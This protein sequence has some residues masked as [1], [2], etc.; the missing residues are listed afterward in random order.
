MS[1]GSPAIDARLRRQV[2]R[3][4]LVGGLGFLVD[5]GLL[6]ALVALGAN[7]YGARV[8]SF[9]AAVTVTWALNRSWTFEQR[10]RAGAGRSYVGYAVVQVTGALANFL[11]YTGVLHFLAPTPGNAVL[12]LACGAV[13]G[14]AVNFTGARLVFTPRTT[15]GWPRVGA[16]GERRPLPR[17][18]ER[19]QPDDAM[20]YRPEIDGLRAVAVLPVVLFHA[21]FEAFGGG[22]VGVDVFFVISG[23]LITGIIIDDLHE[24]RFSITNFYERRAR[25]I[26]PALFLVLI[27][28]TVAA[29]TLMLPLQFEEFGKGLVAVSLFVSNI[30]FWKE[31]GYFESDADL[32]PL[33]HTWS[34]AVEEQYYLFFPIMLVLFWRFGTRFLFWLILAVALASL[35]LTEWGWRHS[36]AA[37]FYLAPTRVWELFVGSLC[38]F[39]QRD[40][41]CP[42]STPLSAAGLALILIA[43]FAYDGSTPFPSLHALTPVAGTALIILFG[44]KPTLTARLLSLRG[45]VFIGLISFSFYLWHQPI[46]AFARIRNLVEPAPPVMGLLSA[47]S[48][49]LAVLSWRYVERPFRNRGVVSRPVIFRASAALV[50]LFCVLGGYIVHDRGMTGRPAYQDL[51]VMDYQPE[52]R[53]LQSE[54]WQ[55]LRTLSGSWRYGVDRNPFDR[56]LWFAPDDPRAGLLI[57][58]NSYSKDLYNV[59]VNSESAAEH[60][61]I[62]RFGAQISEIDGAFFASPNYIHARIVVIASRFTDEDLGA[63][64]EFV[65]RLLRDGKTVAVADN[66]FEFTTYFDYTLADVLLLRTIRERGLSSGSFRHAVDE[67]NRAYFREFSG[68]GGD[69]N[70]RVR[71]VLASVTANHPEVIVLDRMDYACNKSAAVC[72]TI[73]NN[74]IKYIFDYAHHTIEGAKFFGSRVD[75]TNWL[76]PLTGVIRPGSQGMVSRGGDRASR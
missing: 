69:A 19:Q 33:L 40:G 10:R 75:L 12:A 51:L 41:R 47:L 68:A 14:L 34:L 27:C 56:V 62:A 30:L 64:P 57:V 22:F 15:P 32:N 13:V 39:L 11:I 52:N 4:G 48:L 53:L 60:F 26:L 73:D 23:Y 21:G 72:Y 37:N 2:L 9:A 24:G 38:A 18:P 63:L 31:S 65:E 36:P 7:P 28:S 42:P 46:F 3:Y 49:V 17:Q 67:I 43:V 8:A 61:Q 45:L 55:P 54:T 20:K 6:Y 5:A 58:G 70:V 66:L 74:L 71:E 16:A 59:L 50:A 25:R 1:R 76:E 35:A 29:W 44:G